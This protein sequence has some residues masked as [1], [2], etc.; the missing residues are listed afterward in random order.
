MNMGTMHMKLGENLGE[1]LLNIAQEKIFKGDPLGAINTYTESLVGIPEEYVVMILKNQAVLKTNPDGINMDFS[2]DPQALKE[3]EKNI[4]DWLNIISKKDDELRELT[5]NIYHHETKFAQSARIRIND[6]NLMAYG[7]S[8][9][10]GKIHA[11]FHHI[12]AR[13]I[14]NIPF[15]PC[16]SNGEHVWNRI[17]SNV[18]NDDAYTYERVYYHLVNYMQCIRL[19]LE[20]YKKL[21]VMYDWLLEKELVSHIPFIEKNFERCIQILDE[22]AD[23]NTG[24]HHPMCDEEISDFKEEITDV[25]MKTRWGKEY[26]LYG[27]TIKDIMDG[28]DAGWLSPTGEF[29]GAN[30][31]TS[32][33]IHM[34]IAQVLFKG[35]SVYGE[36]MRKDG[37]S[38]FSVNSPEQWLQKKGWVKI[39][40]QDCYGSFIG[41][42]D[43]TDYPYCPTQA[44]I[45]MIC[46]YADALYNGKFYTEYNSLGLGRHLHP[47][48]YS[49]YKVK[50]MDNIMLHKIFTY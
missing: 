13:L 6:F 7:D 8:Q 33:M 14:A 1:I 32:A 40:H 39:H 37:V 10:E 46:K 24:F 44:Q 47:E 25:I 28:Y 48:P 27:T 18:E 5:K 30:G 35:K 38:I 34:N 26:F 50:Q 41:S 22:F 16:A 49:T 29:F 42:K 9:E 23:P 4:Y 2:D 45:K 17:V 20:G 43:W 19:L 3:N 36:E 15:A 11:G 31:E 12:V 21:S